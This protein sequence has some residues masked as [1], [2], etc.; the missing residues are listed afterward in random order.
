MLDAG[1]GSGAVSEA[2]LARQPDVRLVML[3]ASAAMLHEAPP[4]LAASKVRGDVAAVPFPDGTF[5]VVVSAWV[6]ETVADP[7][8][9][10]RDLLRVLAPGGQLLLV[11][12]ALPAGRLRQRVWRPVQRVIETEFAG[13]FLVDGDVPF[14]DC[15]ASSRDRAR[16]RPAATMFMADCCVVPEPPRRHRNGRGAP[17]PCGTGR[18]GQRSAPWCPAHESVAGPDVRH[19]PAADDVDVKRPSANVALLRSDQPTEVS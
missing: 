9:V 1:A 3:D 19:V 12:S 18:E 5:D 17:A 2:I 8:A 11:F 13:R 14:H 6:L 16:H 15:P 10:V 7:A 4:G